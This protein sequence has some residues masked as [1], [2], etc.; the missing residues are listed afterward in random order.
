MT[1]FP[2]DVTLPYTLIFYLTQ[3]ASK[4]DFGEKY[5]QAEF[6]LEQLGLLT[7]EQLKFFTKIDED[8]LGNGTNFKNEEAFW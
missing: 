4:I 8:F 6:N 5:L 2:I 7:K 3:F 1:Y